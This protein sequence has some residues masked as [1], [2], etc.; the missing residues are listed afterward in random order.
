MAFV[1]SIPSE[2]E[3]VR[4][5]L[6]RYPDQGLALSELTEIIMRSGECEFSSSE[7]ELIGAFVLCEK[8][9]RDAIADDTGRCRCDLRCRLE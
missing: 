8:A 1:K 6:G 3:S 7:R 2:Q 4:A 5:V 9:E